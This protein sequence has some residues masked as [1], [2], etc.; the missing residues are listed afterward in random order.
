MQL[1]TPETRSTLDDAEAH[2]RSE[3]YKED[4][5]VLARAK[6]Y[7][8]RTIGE[9]AGIDY[10]ISEIKKY[11]TDGKFSD[12]CYEYAEK[13]MPQLTEEQVAAI[14]PKNDDGKPIWSWRDV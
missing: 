7:I 13:E 8:D 14:L 11:F 9:E 2:F 1:P 12:H 4:L 3:Q 10:M 5:Q 6:T